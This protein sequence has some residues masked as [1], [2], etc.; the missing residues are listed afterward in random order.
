MGR[1]PVCDFHI[2]ENFISQKHAKVTCLQDHIKV[3][4]LNSTNHIYVE[5][6]EIKEAYINLNE[7]FRIGSLEF[8]LKEGNPEEFAVSSLIGAVVPKIS[9]LASASCEKT[10]ACLN[11]FDKTLIEFLYL[12]CRLNNFE[13][14]LGWAKNSLTSILK[15]GQVMLLREENRHFQVLSTIH[16]D[17]NEDP[18]P[19]NWMD[20]KQDLLRRILNQKIGAQC[21]IYSFPLEL[22]NCRGTLIYIRKSLTPLVK[23]IVH[24]LDAFSAEVSLIYSLIESNRF[25]SQRTQASNAMPTII[26]DDKTMLKMLSKCK[27]IATSSIT[28]LI[29]GETGTGK[30]LLARFI[31]CH[32]RQEKEKYVAINCSAFHENLLEVELFGYEKGAFTDAK[33]RQNG[34]LELASGGTLVLDEISEMS[35]NMQVKLLRVL[36]ENEFYRVGGNKKVKVN[37]RVISLTNKSLEKLIGENLFRRDLYFRIAQFRIEIPPLR[38]R[39]GDILPLVNYFFEKFSIESGIYTNGFSP[40]AVDALLQ[41]PWPGNVRE[42]ES[43]IECLVNQ[44]NNHDII[45]FNLLKKE[46][47]T[48]YLR[49]K[50]HTL[51]DHQLEEMDREKERIERLLMEN[52]WNKSRVALILNVS[53]TA[54]YKKLKKLDIR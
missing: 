36:Q 32:S 4:D 12:G 34:K 41:Y 31:H 33:S 11:L 54:L 15:T 43:E 9:S 30:E 3:E 50:D 21:S 25:P 13:E 44:S 18:I 37:L 23:K 40:R 24:F 10:E 14:I 7:S 53:R 2:D 35:L 22:T 46:I 45:D 20:S 48:Y 52:R 27:K 29:E 47:R 16:L 8:F 39:S 6:E 5:R 26:Y 49:L 38:E 19:L 17:K 1:D 42:L 28:L 51:K